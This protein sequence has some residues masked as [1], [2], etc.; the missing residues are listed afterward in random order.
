[1]ESLARDDHQWVVQ[2]LLDAG[3]PLDEIRS[4]VFG[5]AFQG[6]VSEGREVLAC[7]RDLVADRPAEVRAAWSEVVHRLF[8]LEPPT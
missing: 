3:L 7:I 8:L 2:P 4:L 6:V 1:M 5:L